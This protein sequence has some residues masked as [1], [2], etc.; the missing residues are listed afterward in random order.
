MVKSPPADAGGAGL[1]P[2]SGRSPGRGNS[3]PLENFCL[4]NPMDR[5]A[6]QATV[7]EVAKSRTNWVT[8]C[9]HTEYKLEAHKL[10]PN[11]L[12]LNL[13]SERTIRIIQINVMGINI[14]GWRYVWR[15][16]EDIDEGKHIWLR[17][18]KKLVWLGYGEQEGKEEKVRQR[19][20]CVESTS[21]S[22]PGQHNKDLRFYS[23]ARGS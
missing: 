13:R 21:M 19:Y 4:G 16:Y 17:N 7:Y 2:G 23:K 14:S 9:E 12:A 11:K 3:N 20:L 15:Y 22:G 10:F 1:I 5:G 8:E 6:W 18:K